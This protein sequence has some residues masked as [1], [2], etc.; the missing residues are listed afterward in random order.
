VPG[1]KSRAFQADVLETI[2]NAT[3][4]PATLTAATMWFHLYNVQLADQN[5][6]ATTGRCAGANYDSVKKVNSTATWTLASA[7]SPS[8]MENKVT[9]VFTTNAS[10]GW[11]TIKAVQITSSSGTGGV[12]YYWAD[13]SPNQ[14]VT[15]GNTVQLSTGGLEITED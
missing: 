3:G 10:T 7:A 14:T 5:T 9:I 12:S 15:A 13:V 2:Q 4:A 6:P 11:G 1:S 8:A